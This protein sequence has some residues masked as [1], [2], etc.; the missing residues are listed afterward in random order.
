MRTYCKNIDILNLQFLTNCVFE[1]LEGKWK[2]NDVIN[3]L[4]KYSNLSRHEIKEFIYKDQ[5]QELDCVITNIAKDIQRN[6]ENKTIVLPPIKYSERYDNCSKKIRIIGT[7]SIIH[8]CYEYVAVNACKELFSN[9]FGVYQCAS[10]PKRGQSYGKKAIEKWVK[11][12]ISGTRYAVKMDVRKCYPSV[13]KERVKKYLHRDLHKNPTLL[14]LL[15]TLIDMNDNGLSIGSHLSQ[16]LCNYYLSYAYHYISEKLFIQRK[17]K[18]CNKVVNVRLLSHVIFY[19]DDILIFGGNKKHLMIVSKLVNEYFENELGLKI[20]PDW[21]LFKVEYIDKNGK[22]HGSFVDMMGFRFYRGKTTIRRS[23]FIRIKR[24]MNRLRKKIKL[25][26]DVNMK[27]A[28]SIMSYWG[29]VKNTNSYKFMRKYEVSKLTYVA[30]NIVS[31][32][33]QMDKAQKEKIRKQKRKIKMRMKRRKHN[34][35]KL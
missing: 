29:W 18:R 17:S 1:C 15:Y 31:Y 30:R 28:Q 7:Q 4:S 11:Y 16:W 26:R 19:M 8:Q 24:K 5:K 22:V 6:I 23:I 20:K 21:R 32:Y 25:N 9:K 10:I 35:K 14:Y 13:D 2:R 33:A 34:V 3:L 27:Y 12:D